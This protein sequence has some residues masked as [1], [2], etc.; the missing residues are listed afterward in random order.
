[1]SIAIGAYQVGGIDIGAFERQ[2]IDPN[3]TVSVSDDLNNWLDSRVLN[4]FYGIS[5]SDSFSLT[6]SVTNSAVNSISLSD[7]F[8]LTDSIQVN[9]AIYAGLI[10]LSFADSMT[11]KDGFIVQTLPEIIDVS[12]DDLSAY[13]QD[14]VVISFNVFFNDNP[15]TV[16]D[17]LNNWADSVQ[18]QPQIQI[19]IFDTLTMS[20]SLAQF[21]AIFVSVGDALEMTDGFDVYRVILP[22]I[23]DSL[24]FWQDYVDLFTSGN[25]AISVGDSLNFWADGGTTPYR[26]TAF[27]SY[28][29]RYLNDV[30]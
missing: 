12:I 22:I 27:T 17:S 11:M 4:Y 26:G 14:S 10:S 25:L 18:I 21:G 13:L 6:D 16:G 20:D 29:R 9:Y 7:S 24:D 2:G 5:V 15:R 28:I 3:L 23:G 8:T 30:V 1:M 19:L